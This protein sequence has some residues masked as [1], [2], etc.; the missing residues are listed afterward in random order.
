MGGTMTIKSEVDKVQRDKERD[1]EW[2]EHVAKLTLDNIATA[3]VR[4]GLEQVQIAGRMFALVKRSLPR[5]RRLNA[6]D[7]ARLF[8]AAVR[9]LEQ[10]FGDAPVSART[11]KI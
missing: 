1:R 3:R 8:V 10:V 7:A 11:P 9:A 2:D 5:Q 6:Q 4:L